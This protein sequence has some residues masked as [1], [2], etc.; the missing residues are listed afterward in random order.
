MS[1]KEPTN[2]H[3]LIKEK[4]EKDGPAIYRHLGYEQDHLR[5]MIRF[6]EEEEIE[7]VHSLYL[8]KRND[9]GEIVDYVVEDTQR[10]LGD[11]K[12]NHKNKHTHADRLKNMTFKNVFFFEDDENIFEQAKAY[13]LPFLIVTYIVID[14]E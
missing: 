13:Q 4:M 11:L 3:K 5:K 14:S 6:Q 10:Y 9:S 2:F 1:K 8:P 12:R 7:F